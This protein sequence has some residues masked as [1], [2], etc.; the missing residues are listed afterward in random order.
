MILPSLRYGVLRL[1]ASLREVRAFYHS[2]RWFFPRAA[3]PV[4]SQPGD[5]T[6]PGSMSNWGVKHGVAAGYAPRERGE[7]ELTA[8]PAGEEPVGDEG[9]QRHEHDRPEQSGE[10]QRKEKPD[11]PERSEASTNVSS[12][13]SPSYELSVGARPAGRSLAPGSRT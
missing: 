6:C 10:Q 12:P 3:V 4:W 9:D 8:S 5:G 2:P 7:L 13:K 1:H 11:H